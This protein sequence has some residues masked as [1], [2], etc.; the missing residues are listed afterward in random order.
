MSAIARRKSS[1]VRRRV[2]R[3]GRS[4]EAAAVALDA[5]EVGEVVLEDRPEGARVVAVGGSLRRHARCEGRGA[6]NRV[7]RQGEVGDAHGQAEKAVR[8]LGPHAQLGRP[9]GQAPARLHEQ[10]VVEQ[11]ILRAHGEDGRRQ[12]AQIGEQG[13]DVGVAA[14]LAVAA[15]KELVPE[16]DDDRDRRAR[17]CAR[18]TAAGSGSATGQ[19]RRTGRPRPPEGVAKAVAVAQAQEGHRA[20]DARPRSRPRWPAARRR[21]ARSRRR[22]SISHSAAASQSSGA[23]G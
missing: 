11:R 2:G 16:P 12:A 18:P 17:G 9:A 21:A 3:A 8:R 20:R 14:L 4:R 23:A 7:R 15:G 1:G 10:R 19:R 22:C 6:G 5:G 13:R